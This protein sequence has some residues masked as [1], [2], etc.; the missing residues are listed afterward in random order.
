[1]ALSYSQFDYSALGSTSASSASLSYTAGQPILVMAA[2]PV[3]AF[4]PTISD[5]ATLTWNSLGTKTGTNE[6]VVAWY[7]IPS[8]AGST[9]ITVSNSAL[10]ILGFRVCT[11]TGAG[12]PL[13]VGSGTTGAITSAT[14]ISQVVSPTTSGSALFLF[15]STSGG[16]V[17]TIPATANAGCTVDSNSFNNS[18]NAVWGIRPTTNPLTSNSSFTLSAT[19]DG[20]SQDD[21]WLAVEVPFAS[22]TTNYTLSGSAGSYTYTGTSATLFYLAPLHSNGWPIGGNAAIGMLLALSGGATNYSLSGSVGSYAYTGQT[23]TFKTGRLLSGIKGTYTYTGTNS[24]FKVGH[25]LSGVTGS[26]SLTGNAGTLTYTPGSTSTH[27]TLSGVVGSYVYTG[28]SSTFKVGRLLSGSVGSF[29][30]TGNIGTFKVGHTLLGSTGSYTY[31]GNV[32]SFKIG[33][34][35]SGTSGA[36]TYTGNAATLTYI[37]GNTAF[38]Y[39]LSGTTGSYSYTGNVGLFKV[40]HTLSGTVGSYSYTGT[41]GTFKVAHTL[42]GVVGSYSLTGNAGSFSRGYSLLGVSGS[43]VYSGKPGTLTYHAGSGGTPVYP[44]PS[45]VAAGVYYGPTGADFLG[46]NIGNITLE[47]TTGQLIK[48][49]TS[50]VSIML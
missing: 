17:N 11:F 18:F 13:L 46:T 41:L 30:Y 10:A 16:T 44:L 36:Y 7:A 14:T 42:S 38:H 50:S 31:T 1:M 3:A 4:N 19:T 37:P 26:Y 48:P 33:H 28:T 12:T 9:T 24:T 29:S 35:L 32:G 25:T 45:Q 43:Y 5:T 8:G 34:T 22:S 15:V 27:Y 47:M 40:S 23:G 20:T 39:T 21:A 49:L 2:A 6:Q